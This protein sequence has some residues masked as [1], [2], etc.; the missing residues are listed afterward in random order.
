MKHETDLSARS[1][2]SHLQRKGKTE[3]PG[4][5]CVATYKEGGRQI[6]LENCFATYK[7]RGGQSVLEDFALP[8]EKREW[9]RDS[10]QVLVCHI[11]RR[12]KTERPKEYWFATCND[13]GKTERPEKSWFATYKD[14]RKAERPEKSWFATE[15][16]TGAERKGRSG[17]TTKKGKPRQNRILK[18]SWSATDRERPWEYLGSL[19][20]RY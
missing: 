20:S 5:L 11:Q 3:R 13:Q 7:E 14:K 9:D 1:R 17:L 4:R 19:K 18:G 10:R 16:K 2:F 6:V 8:R 12:W 15:K